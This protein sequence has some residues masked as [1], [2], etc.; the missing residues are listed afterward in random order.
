MNYLIGTDRPGYTYPIAVL[1]H[2]NPRLLAI[3]TVV[4]LWRSVVIRRQPSGFVAIVALVHNP[5]VQVLE[6]FWIRHKG[7]ILFGF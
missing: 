4:C 3:G 6:K 2:T 1:I 5:V 7:I